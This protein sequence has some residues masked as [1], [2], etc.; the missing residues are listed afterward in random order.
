MALKHNLFLCMVPMVLG[1][2]FNGAAKTNNAQQSDKQSQS[3]TMYVVRRELITGGET[4][5]VY[6]YSRVLLTDKHGNTLVQDFPAENIF[7]KRGDTLVVRP[8]G[9]SVEILKNLTLE[10][11]INKY[12]QR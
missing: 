9:N 8:R 1:A 10:R 12:R 3:K 2:T 6:G 5:G 4:G 7:V 11:E